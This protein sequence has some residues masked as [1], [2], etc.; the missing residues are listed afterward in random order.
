MSEAWKA[1][2]SAAMDRYACGDDAAFSELYD[3][4]APKLSAFLLRRSR[5]PSTAEDLLQ[6]TFLQMHGARRNFSPGAEV[7]PWAYA[8]ARRLFIDTLR[9]DGREV[10]GDGD[11]IGGGR[12]STP[13]EAS[14][15]VLVARQRLARRVDEELARLPEAQRIAFELVQRDG[16]S[17]AETAQVL[18]TTVGAVKLRAFRTYEALR[19]A[20]GDQVREE[21][22]SFA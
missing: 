10:L 21:L 13:P 6:Q 17:M 8:I 14:P 5:Q 20:L 18:G 4:L 1:A 22:S 9:K 2:A 12:E 19:A 7:A 11:D 3:L 15:D 16:L